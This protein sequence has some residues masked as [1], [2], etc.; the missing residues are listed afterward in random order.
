MFL[1]FIEDSSDSEVSGRY[2]PVCTDG[3]GDTEDEE[4]KPTPSTSTDA[5]SKQLAQ[6]LEELDM[7][8]EADMKAGEESPSEGTCIFIN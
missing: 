1:L 3:E 4:K 7:D 2:S 6:D 5:K 8:N